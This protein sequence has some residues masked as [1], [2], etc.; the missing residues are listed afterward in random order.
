MMTDN[1][2][3]VISLN[4]TT[5]SDF[6]YG[7]IGG[8]NSIMNCEKSSFINIRGTALKIYSPKVL[9]VTSS[10]IQ[11]CTNEG[12]DIYLLSSENSF[13]RKLLI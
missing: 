5:I 2:I 11:K 8:P 4:S 10:V 1:F 12:I 6:Y 3:G 9:K 7:I 13:S